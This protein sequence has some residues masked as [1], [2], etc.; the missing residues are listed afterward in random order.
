MSK[1]KSIKYI[2]NVA[3]SC[4][5]Y[6]SCP[7]AKPHMGFHPV[8]GCPLAGCIRVD[9]KKQQCLLYLK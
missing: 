6:P 1:K 4:N 2:C 8:Y 7:H 3:Q 9:S 5:H